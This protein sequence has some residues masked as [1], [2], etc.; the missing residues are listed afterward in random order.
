MLLT[1]GLERADREGLPVYLEATP[2]GALVY[3]KFG[4]RRVRELVMF[5]GEYVMEF[6]IRPT[7]NDRVE[8]SPPKN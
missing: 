8:E 4:F 1:P 7:P 3:P 6:F 5:E 2:A